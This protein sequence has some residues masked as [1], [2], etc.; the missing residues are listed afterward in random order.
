MRIFAFPL[1]VT[2]VLLA[3]CTSPGKPNGGLSA[4]ATSV[5]VT[6]T[7]EAST[8][9]EMPLQDT[10]WKLIEIQSIPVQNPEANQSEAYI[11]LLS[12]GL[13]LQGSG[14]CNTLMGAYTMENGN[15]I[16]FSAVASTRMACPEMTTESELIRVIEMADNYAIRGNHLMLHNAKM[17]PLAKFE[18]RTQ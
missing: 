8:P 16:R 18:A 14:G 13:K 11:I 4:P 2:T 3:K 6:Q 5:A 12:E 1:L 10:Y 9:S 15:R 17:A 7:I